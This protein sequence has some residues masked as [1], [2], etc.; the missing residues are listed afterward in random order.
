[1]HIKRQKKIILQKNH[2]LKKQQLKTKL[3]E[4]NTC[5]YQ[6]HNNYK[7]ILLYIYFFYELPTIYYS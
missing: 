3:L 4:N 1:M 5:Y 7:Q 2:I 6:V